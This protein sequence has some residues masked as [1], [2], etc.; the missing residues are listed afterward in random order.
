MN[1]S[2]V[3]FLL[4]LVIGL[5][6]Q[7]THALNPI[8]PTVTTLTNSTN[9][10]NDFTSVLGNYIG[11]VSCVASSRDGSEFYFCTNEV[12]RKVRKD[13]TLQTIAGI[14][15]NTGYN[16]DHNGDALKAKIDSPFSLF[17]DDSNGDLYFTDS[18]NYL[19]RKID[20]NGKI[21]D[22]AGIPRTSGY[23]DRS[24]NSST[25]VGPR[26]LFVHGP[27]KDIYLAD[28]EKVRLISQVNSTV[29][30]IAYY[31]NMNGLVI[32][33]SNGDIYLSAYNNIVKLL[34]NGV[35]SVIAGDGN[36]YNNGYRDGNATQ[37]LFYYIPSLSFK[38]STQELFISDLNNQ[39]VRVLNMNSNQVSTL[40]GNDINSYERTYLP[41]NGK[42]VYVRPYQIQYLPQLDQLLIADLDNRV[43][44]KVDLQNQQA[45]T[46][47]I[48]GSPDPYTI[49]GTTYGQSFVKGNSLAY[50]LNEDSFVVSSY[51]QVVKF[52]DGLTTF[53]FNTGLSGS[54]KY[55]IEYADNQNN[56]Y[57]I[58]DRV[59]Y[60]YLTNGTRLLFAPDYFGVDNVPFEQAITSSNYI[61]I[62]FDKKTSE[63]YLLSLD[64][65][66][67][68]SQN[69]II[70]T[71][72]ITADSSGNS[73]YNGNPQSI[74]IDS[75]S[76]VYFSDRTSIYRVDSLEKSTR[77]I[78]TG[79][80]TSNNYES[81][82]GTDV[83]LNYPLGLT[84]NALDGQLYF[85]DAYNHRI[86]VYNFTSQIVS[87]FSGGTISGYQDGP[88]QTARFYF[89]NGLDIDTTN[90]DLYVSDTFNCVIRKIS[91]GVVSTVAG[92]Y[93]N[94]NYQNGNLSTAS[95][96]YPYYLSYYNGMIFTVYDNELIEISLTGN[97]VERKTTRSSVVSGDN[98]ELS[99]EN[100]LA[101]VAAA[102]ISSIDGNLYFLDGKRVRIVDMDVRTV[103]TIIGQLV[104]NV[105]YTKT[106]FTPYG[107]NVNYN[108]GEMMIYDYEYSRVRKIDANGIVS[109]I[110]GNGLYNPYYVY[111]NITK[112]TDFP[113][114]EFNDFTTCPNDDN[115][116]LLINSY[117]FKLTPDGML[118]KQLD[119]LSIE[120]YT[121]QCTKFG[122]IILVRDNEIYRFDEKEN[123]LKLVTGKS[124]STSM[125]DGLL[126]NATF[127]DIVGIS[128]SPLT[129]AIGVIHMSNGN[130]RVVRKIG[131]PD[132][133]E[134]QDD[135]QTC[136][137]F[138]FNKTSTAACSGNGLCSDVNTC[139]CTSGWFGIECEKP[140]CFGLNGS[141]ACN[142]PFKG[143]CSSFNN[144]TCSN[145]Y[146]GKECGTPIC[147]GL[148]DN[149]ACGGSLN[150][151]C[152]SPNN[153]SCVNNH[154]G[155][156]CSQFDCYGT[157]ST[158]TSVCSGHGSCLS[159]N[160]CLCANNY[161]GKECNQFDCYGTI[162]TS[163]SV[164]SGHGSCFSPN[165]CACVGGWSGSECSTSPK[166]LESQRLG[167]SSIITSFNVVDGHCF[168][169]IVCK[170]IWVVKPINKISH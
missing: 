112:A 102:R 4:F 93:Q 67:K 1:Q 94:T 116:Y 50:S 168:F 128:V 124:G 127:G 73:L 107:V 92:Q 91:N 66:R 26:Q 38:D 55:Q 44:R 126:S 109:T 169:S 141:D 81:G 142:G 17:L 5:F 53:L 82:I 40:L 167:D 11:S 113:L 149:N 97:S 8:L 61:D 33:P 108:S 64:R 131:C 119:G 120:S 106:Q 2:T 63:I 31:Q 57:I 148:I 12:I 100:T 6:C 58:G 21:F 56:I 23:D 147:F 122:T 136:L 125:E 74:E 130:G 161:Y 90:G 96:G 155:N 78:G 152:L 43:I 115:V 34:S 104:E 62:K 59:M 164:C 48:A 75:N 105:H 99:E 153:C 54:N 129:N 16:T 89:P 80:S 135:F 41:Q 28:G 51:Q 144:C 79:S 3:Q 114:M 84:F 69:G 14:Y 52:K 87:T 18:N 10:N 9:T 68:I 154:Y 65:I 157:I 27:N 71:I 70:S 145:E 156:D 137:P 60:K 29:S 30:T 15:G 49:S 140:I 13:G 101:T 20:V 103:S 163:V 138:C 151:S 46:T 121:I 39:R 146:T 139:S 22:I 111:P 86:R 95:I 110:V 162:S 25:F 77:I 7:L 170:W 76:N 35:M 160:N 24:L 132:G 83:Q 37:A 117:F 47:I 166:V 42:D 19:V 32:N 134:M 123:V 159:P 88:I 165:N 98:K 72:H 45:W 133:Y 158:N 85:V 118:R 150:G 143:N 36:N